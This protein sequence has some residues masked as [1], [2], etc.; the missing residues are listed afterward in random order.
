MTTEI[1]Y[2]AYLSPASQTP[3]HEI[4]TREIPES[5]A[6]KDF[7]RKTHPACLSPPRT[8]EPRPLSCGGGCQTA[9]EF[10]GLCLPP[11][12]TCVS[13]SVGFSACTQ[14]QACESSNLGGTHHGRARGMRRTGKGGWEGGRE[15]RKT[16]GRDGGGDYSPSVLTSRQAFE[17]I[18]CKPG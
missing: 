12:L 16:G 7:S 13:F 15:K 9:L 11:L 6:L 10:P 8:P 18:T 17:Q 1:F 14:C 2:L 3:P 4:T 5:P